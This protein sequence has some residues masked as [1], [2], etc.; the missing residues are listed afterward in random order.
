MLYTAYGFYN[1]RTHLKK[2][3]LVESSLHN[4][5]I[6][7]ILS[8]RAITIY[9]VKGFTT[10][11][12][13]I[14]CARVCSSVLTHGFLVHSLFSL[15]VVAPVCISKLLMKTNC[16]V[17]SINFTVIRVQVRL[18]VSASEKRLLHFC[19]SCRHVTRHP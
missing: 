10:P 9:S 4:E 5:Y 19:V 2:V 8:D 16:S 7:F 14:I 13:H 1:S 18:Q 11:Q 12:K 6:G 3:L 15:C 17:E